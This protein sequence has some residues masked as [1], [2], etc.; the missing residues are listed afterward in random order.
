[1]VFI[2]N[3]LVKWAIHKVRFDTAGFL[4][5]IHM[6]VCLFVFNMFLSFLPISNLS[7]RPLA[8][9]PLG[10]HLKPLFSGQSDFHSDYFFEF[11][12]KVVTSEYSA[13]GSHLLRIGF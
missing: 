12:G 5:Q 1:M 3:P 10:F 13:I 11:H 9:I 7:V 8:D 4:P 2:P 6:V